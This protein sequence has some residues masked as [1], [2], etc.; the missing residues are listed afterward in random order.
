[1][2]QS[3]YRHGLR[4]STCPNYVVPRTRT[5]HAKRAFSVSGPVACNALSANI[6]N[7]ADPKLF[8][9]L[10]KTYFFKSRGRYHCVT[11][12][13]FVIRYWTMSICIL[14]YTK[15]LLYFVVLYCIV[16]CPWLAGRHTICTY[17]SSNLF[18]SCL[19]NIGAVIRF[20]FGSL[21]ASSTCPTLRNYCHI[22]IIY[23]FLCRLF[24]FYLLTHT[25]WQNGSSYNHEVLTKN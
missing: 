19:Q 24:I 13:D 9:L 10:L 15:W 6:R 4:S 3:A 20:L 22:Y 14:W 16:R 12:I 8:K 5:K 23:T 7:T 25:L 2:V 17:P 11:F 18:F 1:M 21:A